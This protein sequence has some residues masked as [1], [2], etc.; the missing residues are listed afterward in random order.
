MKTIVKVCAADSTTETKLINELQSFL[1][2][3]PELFIVGSHGACVPDQNNEQ[4]E[5]LFV[6]SKRADLNEFLTS[7][8]RKGRAV[9]LI[10]EDQD[11]I[12]RPLLNG[13]V[14]DVLVYPFRR[15]EVLSKLN[16]YRQILMWHEVHELNASFSEVV[17]ELREDLKLAERLQKAKL[18]IRFD[19]VRGFKVVSRYLAGVKPGGDYFDLADS[20]D[21]RILSILMSDSSSYGLSSAVLSVLMRIAVRLSTEEARSSY[22]T[23]KLIYRE[24]SLVL[25][26]RDQL[27]LFYGIINRE[28]WSLKYLNLGTSCAFFSPHGQEFKELVSQGGAINRKQRLPENDCQASIS[29]SPGDRLALVSDG[30]VEAVGGSDV[31][32]QLLRNLRDKDPVDSVNELVFRVKSKLVDEDDMPK[33]DCSAI[34]FDVDSKVIRLKRK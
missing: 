22:D 16:Q 21:G 7:V 4:G 29:L 20:R 9:F 17:D 31:V 26:E 13:L 23:V 6:E 8:D 18:P 19:D 2:S 34:I 33:Q 11:D 32:I 5:V 24:L 14:D 1:S 30:Y 25:A 10:V 12:P 28:D 15:L 3:M 27:S